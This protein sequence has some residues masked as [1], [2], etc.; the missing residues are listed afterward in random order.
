MIW[1]SERLIKVLARIERVR[2][3]LKDAK[4]NI[5]ENFYKAGMEDLKVINDL[6][7]FIL[8]KFMAAQEIDAAV[9]EQVTKYEH[10]K[11]G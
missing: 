10:I 6:I 5:N 11:R 1:I 3:V 4:G 2:Y 8:L 9:R 7:T